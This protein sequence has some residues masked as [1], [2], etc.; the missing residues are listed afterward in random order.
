MYSMTM[1]RA[2]AFLTRSIRQESR[3]MSHHLMRG[4]LAAVILALFLMQL[5]AS[6]RF[7][8]AGSRFAGAIIQSFYW[9]LTVVG[10]LYYSVSITEEKEEDTLPLLRMTGVTDFAL[11]IGKSLPRLAVAGLFVLVVTPF[12]VLSITMGGVVTEQL[13]S[14]LL[15]LLCYSFLLSQLGL[16]ASTVA[17]DG[18]RA[19][20]LALILW[21]GFESGHFLLWALSATFKAYGNHAAAELA[22]SVSAWLSTRVLWSNLD[23]YLS[24]DRGDPIWFPQMTWHL[25]CGVGCFLLS[26][27]LFER[28]NSRVIG[29]G[30]TPDTSHRALLWTKQQRQSARAVG[31]AL[32]WKSWHF[33]LG[34]WRW[35]LIRLIALPTLVIGIVFTVGL[36]VQEVPEP[37]VFAITLMIASVCMLLAELAR[38]LG[39]VLNEEVFRLTLV[40]LRMIPQS[41]TQIVFGLVAGVLPVAG[42]SL[43]C[44]GLGFLAL[45]TFDPRE[46]ADF[47]T[48]WREP[49]YWHLFTWLLLTL[50]L[51]VLLSVYL[52][53]GG[54]VIAGALLWIAAPMLMMTMIFSLAIATGLATAAGEIFMRY[55]FPLGLIGVECVLCLIMQRMI[56]R[57]VDQVV[58]S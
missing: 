4:A 28:C 17:T 11:L 34:G 41:T 14:C 51:G 35:M 58:E 27:L 18:R 5:N 7:G 6:S 53:Y 21:L 46:A 15:G 19:F 3:L 33:L 30:M 12:T 54:M 8:A 48:I 36:M 43:L 50:H 13:L 55:I 16:L 23:A 39:R 37:Q 2:S 26:W 24:A 42:P 25:V 56:L 44:F 49:W 38:S 40:S 22:G 9:F 31:N 47:L 29:Q 45:A 52:R 20:S 32:T 10:L 1:Q 57:R